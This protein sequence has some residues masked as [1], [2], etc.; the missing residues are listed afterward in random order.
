L[1]KNLYLQVVLKIIIQSNKVY[2]KKLTFFIVCIALLGLQISEAQVRRITG[3]VTSAADGTTIP[4]ASVV[5]KGTSLGTITNLDGAYQLDVPPGAEALMVS[6]VG[7]R[8]QEVPITGTVVNAV[9]EMEVVGVEEIMVVAYGTTK[10]ESFTGSAEVISAEKLEK[11]TVANISKALDG[12]APGIQTTSGSGQPGAGSSVVIRGFGSINASNNPLYVV[13]GIPYDGSIA[14]I[15]PNDIASITILKDASAGALY[16]ARG[17]N[18]VILITTKRGES[19]ETQYNLKGSWGISARAI[20]RY[21]T[22]NQAQ[23]IENVYQGY[24]NNEIISNGLDPQTAA[25]AAVT[26][27]VSGPRR[28]FGANEMYNP[29]NYPA[30]QLIDPV[31]GKVRTDATL[32]WDEDWLDEVTAVNPLRQEYIFSATGTADKTKYLFSLG[33]LNED[34]LLKT[35]S[36]KRYTGRTNIETSAK[37]WFEAGLSANFAMNESN[38]SQTGTSAYSNVFY[39]NQLMGPIYPIY[40]RDANGEIK[41]DAVG[42]PVFDYG[43]TRPDGA[44]SNFNS[45]ATLYEDKYGTKTDN[46]SGRTYMAFGDTDTGILQGLKLSLNLGYDYVN[47]NGMVYYNPNF[48]NAATVKG[49]ISRSNG[50]TFSYTFNQ[51]LTW[52]RKFGRHNIDLLGGHEYYAYKYNYLAGAKSGYPFGG[53]YELDAATTITSASSY[54]NNYR[55]ESVLSR[56]NYNFDDKYYVSLSYRTDGTSRFKQEYRWG[57]FWSAGANWRISEENFMDDISWL[58]NLSLK[59]SYG[60]QGN[61]AVGSFYAWQ[62]FYDLGWPNANM[63]GAAVSSLENTKLKWELNKNFNT[64]IEAKLFDRIN[65]SVEYYNRVTEDMLLE[66]PIASSLGFDSYLKNVGSME[67]KGI[68]ATL[69]GSLIKTRDL[70]WNL[71]LMGATVNNKVLKLADKP[72]IITGSY[73]IKEGEELYSFYV[74]R[75]AGVDPATGFMVYHVYEKD[76]D[77]NKTYSLSTDINKANNSKEIS[78]SRIPDLYGSVSSDITYKGFDLSV[79]T[80]YSLG[81]HVLDGNY[82]NLMTGWYVGQA[83]HVNRGRAWKNPGDVTDIPR[84]QIGTTYPTTTNDLI[85]ASY[86][87]IKNIAAG[88]T[89]PSRWSQKL[90]LESVRFSLTGDN[91][92]LFTHLKGMDPQYNFT[93]GTTYIYTPAKTVSF[94]VDIKF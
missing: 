60:V 7:M 85:D 69:G 50:R 65:L 27:M 84:V 52:N 14:A 63:S 17:A 71:T 20:P 44:N 74:T 40:E 72:E 41:I 62:S 43:I 34:G 30:A 12:M 33:Y 18:G 82:R 79:M 61:D 55:I 51:L 59:A 83:T 2:M 66:Y 77:D 45:V 35:T 28:I 4:G 56:L 6:F 23:W 8:T 80:T 49:S 5:V 32:K 70:T 57:E 38:T 75:T 47:S 78:G 10:K 67:N 89:I 37:D 25:T 94:G 19:G 64:G 24:K 1:L 81:G 22:M 53:L 21:E 90:S 16:G 15:N 36:F 42:K 9:L 48:G 92:F 88:Y 86:F 54:E 76:A 58:D 31:T 29:F 13:D 68:E 39:T 73:I 3:T 26:A 46:I 87:A 11:R 91:L 93:G